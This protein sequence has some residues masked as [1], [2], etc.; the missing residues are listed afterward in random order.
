MCTGTRHSASLAARGTVRAR[1]TLAKHVHQPM[2]S[3]TERKERDKGRRRKIKGEREKREKGHAA[4]G[5]PQGWPERRG[6]GRHGPAPAGAS[7]GV[8]AA[9][10]GFMTYVRIRAPFST[11]DFGPSDATQ[12]HRCR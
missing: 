9:G 7:L 2:G 5:R 11:P 8:T 10:A 1:V 12:A 3:A 4:G 6:S